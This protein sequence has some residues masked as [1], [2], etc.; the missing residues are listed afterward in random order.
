[1]KSII[2]MII[3]LFLIVG[4]AVAGENEITPEDLET[5]AP[6]LEDI[7][8][9][10]G[11]DEDCMKEQFASAIG[12]SK[13]LE[14]VQNLPDTPGKHVILAIYDRC[15]ILTMDEEFSMN[16]SEMRICVNRLLD[17]VDKELNRLIIEAKKK[18]GV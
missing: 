3:A 18:S 8:K 1:M 12:L 11:K 9:I 7:D 13:G 16:F 4:F 15:A 14:H 5:I 2:Y 10:C 17:E 6:I